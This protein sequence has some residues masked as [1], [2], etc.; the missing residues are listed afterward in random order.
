[1]KL[2]LKRILSIV[3]AVALAFTGLAVTASA[4]DV[5]TSYVLSY[6]GEGAVPY[7]YGSRYECK[8]SYNDPAAGENSVWT[9]WNAPEIF[10]L[11]NTTN[12][13][14]IPAY[15]T[16][17]DTSTRGDTT[18]RR[19][20]LEDSSFYATG[21]AGKLRSII[22][23]T[24]PRLTVEEVAAA[25]NLAAGS[26]VVTE[27]TQGEVISATQQAIWELAHGDKYTVDKHYV[28]IRGMSSYDADEFMY[29]ES[30]DNC[31]E[32]DYTAGNIEAL[33]NYFLSLDS[34][35]PS[36]DAVSEYTFENVNYAS[37]REEDGN[38]TVTVTY[39][40][41]TTMDDGDEL[42]LTALCGSETQSSTLTPGAGS[43]TFAG[44]AAAESVTLTISGYEQGGDVYLFDA[45]GDRT[46]SQSMIGYD[47]SLLPVYAEAVASPATDRVLK[48][49]KTSSAAD[50]SIPLKNIT[51]DVYL[52]ASME[53][54]ESGKISLSPAPEGDKLAALQVPEKLVTTLT[55]DALGTASYNLTQGGWPDGVYLVAE[56]YNSATTGPIAP[57][58]VAV[59][60]TSSDGMG[61]NYTVT[62][63]PKNT[64]ETGPDIK[65][66]VTEIE[67]NWDTFDVGE[68]HTWI[69]RADIPAG[70]AEATLYDISDTL[71]YRLTYMDGLE[72]KVGLT[73]DEAGTEAVTLEP[74]TH[75]AVT[76]NDVTDNDG[77][78][79]KSFIVSLT[80]AGIK[81]VASAAGTNYAG[82]E[83]RVYFN[84]V[85]NENAD[86]GVEIPN[87][88]HL[89][90]VNSA[91]VDYD[92][93]SDIPE[94]VTGGTGLIKIDSAESS[95]LAGAQ[96]R[97]A[98]AATEEEIASGAAEKLT[99]DGVSLDVVFVD[100]YA[101]A[102]LTGEKVSVS[103]TNADG[104]LYFCGLS[105]GTY[106]LVETKAPT[107]YN[108]L[109]APITV[110]IDELS[111]TEASFVTVKN[112]RFYLPETGGMG[113]TL[114]T[115]AGS[116]V[117]L[118]SGALLILS[119][120]KKC[121]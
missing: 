80:D 101:A 57:F 94:V 121:E 50:G 8:H 68:T 115:A 30:L 96:F 61:Y 110:E 112:S 41:A 7:L 23:N 104:K 95:P 37:V 66:D 82:S 70:M 75:Y 49:I 13:S 39:N 108:L 100:Y 71:D 45:L 36:N 78:A 103:T 63:Y 114:F 69:I 2:K 29:P 14:S 18:Y 106:Y 65:K 10:N 22:L 86:L 98:R 73:T 9:Y 67:N 105:Y 56:R 111:H 5:T 120:K 54:I 11:V 74:D 3:M 53:D 79:T 107:G 1:M 117:L 91:G 92:S 6:D 19:I 4:T 27:L 64:T 34:T 84:A 21:A 20:N 33:Y 42:T 93:D 89:D 116:A 32:S 60:A 109:R 58:F 77:N 81:A 31:I 59:P 88:A 48:I 16:D 87:R 28:S 25:V 35:A 51:F 40:V 85:I 72:V 99:V 44:L 43:V 119:R 24:F 55:T 46:A 113:T 118:S 83:V 38:Y 52:A 62:V 97:I 76:V 12:G 102:D 47:D 17:A 15:C 90:Y 26:D